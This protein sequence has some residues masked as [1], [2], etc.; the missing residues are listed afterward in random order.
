MTEHIK[1]ATLVSIKSS[2]NLRRESENAYVN[3]GFPRWPLFRGWGHLYAF[4]V[5][6]LSTT[7]TLP[8]RLQSPCLVHL[9]CLL[10]GFHVRS[11]TGV[12]TTLSI[13]DLKGFGESASSPSVRTDS[14]ILA[15]LPGLEPHRFRPVMSG[16]SGG[17]HRRTRRQPREACKGDADVLAGMNTAARGG[18]DRNQTV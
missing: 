10:S 3:L 17:V 6:S 12:W 11:Q 14:G 18:Q 8:P 2:L 1:Y 7:S 16:L 5:Y 4:Y 9:C 13:T 15:C